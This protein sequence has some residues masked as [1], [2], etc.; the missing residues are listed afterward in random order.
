MN[1]TAQVLFG[2]ARFQVLATLFTLDTR[3]AAGYGG[4]LHLREIARRVG[5]SPSAAQYELRLLVQAGLVTVSGTASR[6]RY[7]ANAASPVFREL[8]GMLKKM[9]VEPPSSLIDDN[10]LWAGKRLRQQKDYE[11]NDL[12]RKSPFFLARDLV[13]AAKMHLPDDVEYDY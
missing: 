4:T 8:R 12:A 7:G 11:S 13:K 2:R 1:K 3:A 10:E 5:I 9:S 6:P